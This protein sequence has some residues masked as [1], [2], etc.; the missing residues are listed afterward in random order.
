MKFVLKQSVFF[1]VTILLFAC[2]GPEVKKPTTAELQNALSQKFPG[3]IKL[4][5]FSTE[6]SQN[7]G[8]DVDPVW[9]VR[10]NA[11]ILSVADLYM[12]NNSDNSA[13]FIIL[14]T[15][16]DTE[17]K[18]FGKFKSELYQG[19]WQ[20]H[21]E[22][23]GNPIGNLGLPVNQISKNGKIIIIRG[24]E[25]EKDYFANLQ[26]ARE[27]QRAAEKKRQALSRQ[28]EIERENHRK[29]EKY[30]KKGES[31]RKK[32]KYDEA[33]AY[34]SKAIELDKKYVSAYEERCLTWSRMNQKNKAIS[35]CKKASKLTNDNSYSLW[36]LGDL[37]DEDDFKTA[38][39]FYKKAIQAS[40]KHH[41]IYNGVA[42]FLATC[43]D[44]NYRN[45]KKAVKYA[46]EACVI[47]E[48][49]I[50]SFID[51]LAAAYAEDGNFEDAVRMQKKAIA[52]LKSAEKKQDYEKRLKK[53]MNKQAL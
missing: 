4:Q 3:H 36:K 20:H 13:I 8:N 22:F 46:T 35:D 41:F 29:A 49:K 12:K 7:L 33:I 5:E 30:Y 51:T 10:F 25:E 24:S 26:K 9:G 52:L 1:F 39:M 53:Y 6:A 48:W 37:Y 40:P 15:K 18:I 34:Y 32:K 23:D 14:S 31:S 43:K 2:S 45:G 21:I 19:K 38:D 28:K 50:P 17:T 11:S 47:S 44:N 27:L 42:W 16:K